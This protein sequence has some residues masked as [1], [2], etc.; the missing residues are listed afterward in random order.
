MLYALATAELKT[1]LDGLNIKFNKLFGIEY[2]KLEKNVNYLKYK[3]RLDHE[4]SIIV[5]MKEI[6]KRLGRQIEAQETTSKIATA[7]VW[8]DHLNE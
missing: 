6:Q 3:S 2:D 5:E 8:I 4:L 1:S 7:K